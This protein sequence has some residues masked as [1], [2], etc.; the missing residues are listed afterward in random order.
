MDTVMMLDTMEMDIGRAVHTLAKALDYVGIDDKSHGRRV[1]LIAHR[2]SRVLGW[3]QERRHFVLLAGMLHDC[4]VS[5]TAIHQKLL[6]EM[7]WQGA[8]DH[9]VRGADFLENF[10]PFNIFHDVV[11]YHHT[12]W[13][14]MPADLDQETKEI[15][16]LIYLADRLDVVYAT[17]LQAF[18]LYEVLVNRNEIMDRLEEYVGSL[19]APHLF[20]ALKEAGKRDSFWLELADEYLDDAIFETLDLMD[21][22]VV[23]GFDE[24]ESLG[25][26]ISRIVDAKSPFTHYHSLRVADLAYAIT[27]YLGY[28][29]VERRLIR[30]A[31]LL[32]DVGKLRTPDDILEKPGKLTNAEIAQLRSHPMDSKRVLR[33]IFPDKPIAKWASQHH[34]KLN[35]SGYP[36]GLAA[37]QI[38]AP[39]RVLSI[40]DIFQALSQK[41]PYRGRLSVDAVLEIMDKMIM[42]GDLDPEIYNFIRA[43]KD[44]LYQ[45]AIRESNTLSH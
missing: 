37:D 14:S 28:S 13:E 25:E 26:L 34:E 8:H 41:R 27:G 43:N 3:S 24:V 2:I 40:A 23:M 10:K 44:S 11:L 21:H 42:E 7:E 45:I 16:N 12:R 36:Y 30:I 1:G 15:A 17:G 32:H 18:P 35:G 20:D 6:D 31:A 19:F 5:S 4:G 33:S 29:Q 38:D 39:T 22:K 9:C